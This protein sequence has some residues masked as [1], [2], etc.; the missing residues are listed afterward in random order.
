MAISRY[1]GLDHVIDEA[2]GRPRLESF[3]PIQASEIIDEAKDVIIEFQE[4]MRFDT[5]AFQYL[6][7][8]RYWWAIC[9]IN[10]LQLPFGSAVTPGTKLRIPTNVSRIL[11]VIKRKASID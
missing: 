5:L 6:G 3:P 10:D 9:L 8:G 2:N 1:S 4:G 7:D 11:A